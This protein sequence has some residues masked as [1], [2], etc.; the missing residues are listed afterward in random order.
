VIVTFISFILEAQL[1]SSLLGTS[2]TDSALHADIPL[3]GSSTL[4][5]RHIT[6]CLT[7]HIPVKA[8]AGQAINLLHGDQQNSSHK[9]SIIK[10]F[11]LALLTRVFSQFKET[12][13]EGRFT[14]SKEYIPQIYL[15]FICL[16]LQFFGAS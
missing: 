1:H 16:Q 5:T 7:L 2:L 14:F 10:H 12:Y 11:Q 3:H 13:S 4:P 8:T 9:W 6:M 15:R